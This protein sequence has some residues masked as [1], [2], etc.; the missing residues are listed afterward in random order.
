MG[1]FTSI[2]KIIMPKVAQKRIRFIFS[3]FEN[4][5]QHRRANREDCPRMLELVQEL[6]SFERAPNEVTVTLEHFEESGFGPNPVYWA[7]VA[8]ENGYIV[9]FALYYIRYSTWKGQRMYL[10]DILVTESHRGKKIG[11]KLMDRL[12][13]EAKEK[14]LHGIT[15]QVLEWNEPAIKF[16]RKY[17][18]VFDDEWTNCSIVV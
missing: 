5:N 18:P 12:I 4:G 1:V 15:W 6:A 16:Y 13:I 3:L 8:E 9:A 7:F 2:R 14:S 11:Q 10:E 17:N